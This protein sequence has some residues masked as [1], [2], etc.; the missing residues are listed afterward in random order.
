MLSARGS[1]ELR[2]M[3]YAIKA[4]D[5]DLRRMIYKTMRDTMNPVWQ[6]AVRQHAST[7][8][9]SRVLMAGTNIKAGNP[10]VLQAATSRRRVSGLVPTEHWAGVEYGGT[11]DAYTRYTRRSPRGRSHT[12]E[13]RTMRHLRPRRRAGYVLEHAVTEVLPRLAALATQAVVKTYMDAIDGKR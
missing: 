1:R 10:P 6:G 5:R 9:E 12:V 7:P 13:R 8:L 2:A 3:V 11:Q 4:A